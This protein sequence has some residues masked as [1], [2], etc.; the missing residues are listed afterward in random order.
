MFTPSTELR[1][2][3]NVDITNTYKNTFSFADLASQTTFFL[4]KTKSTFTN[5]LYQRKER[6]VKVPA[7]I[8][9][10]WNVNYM[11]FKNSSYGSKW[12][13]AFIINMKYVNDDTTEIE[14]ELDLIQTWFF[15]M[16]YKKCFV[17]REHVTDDGIGNHLL[18]E[19]LD[20]GS[21][22][23]MSYSNSD[24]IKALTYV[25]ASTV[26]IGGVTQTGGKY[27]GVYSGLTFY[28]S[29]D[30]SWIQSFISALETQGKSDALISIFT[31]PKN[32]VVTDANNKVE[33]ANSGWFQLTGVD[34]YRGT[35]DGYT[36]KNNKM[37]CY[38]YNYLEVTDNKGSNKIFKYEFF[39]SPIVSQFFLSCNVSPSPTVFLTPY[40]YNGIY[41][42][43][44]ESMALGDY[45]LC[46]WSTDVYANWLAQ[47][48]VSN[49]L[50]VGSGLLGV[51]VGIATGNPIGVASGVLS[52]ANSIGTFK[53]MSIAPPKASGGASGGANIARGTQVFSFFKKTVRSE[54][55]KRID[56]YFSMFGYKVSTVKIPNIRTRPSWN[57]VKL[58]EAN[59]FGDI[60]NNDLKRIHSIFKEG[61]TFWHGDFVGSFDLYNGGG[62]GSTG[63]TPDP[64][65]NPDDP[66]IETYPSNSL[67]ISFPLEQGVSWIISST[68]GV[69][70]DPIT[71]E[72]GTFHHGVDLACPGGTDIVSVLNNGTVSLRGYDETLG[73]YVYVNYSFNGNTYQIMC[74]HMVNPA[75]VALGDTVNKGTVLGYVGTTGYSTGNHLHFGLKINGV[76]VDPWDYINPNL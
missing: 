74:F 43:N 35:L 37:L 66:P 49:A 60:P 72:E 70:V 38:P 51:G 10:L 53:E 52:V 67:G 22:V 54:Y 56:D 40:N 57:Y 31:V 61:I 34:K 32:L 62:G 13:Y 46:A 18:E 6:S 14:F 65:P 5:F 20:I 21:P 68:Y 45:P 64:N 73:N 36:P 71:G 8:E 44:D 48:Q 15:D 41:Q 17:E 12:F 28:A 27:T 69:R 63:I 47:N 29:S 1:L 23:T 9:N 50:R 2:L 30:I 75:L 3:G 55:A 59:I 42:N 39:S 4:G 25:I 19:N 16:D 26:D 7:N 33:N 76:H 58:L 11:M 24:I